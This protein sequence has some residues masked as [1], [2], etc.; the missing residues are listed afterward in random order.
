MHFRGI[1]YIRWRCALRN[2][3][4]NIIF[5]CLDISQ[6]STIFLFKKIIQQSETL[7][8]M[9]AAHISS[10]VTVCRSGEGIAL[11]LRIFEVSLT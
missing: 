9:T 4:G 5:G 3:Q 6:L 2:P 1:H 8:N 11:H 10:M 7:K